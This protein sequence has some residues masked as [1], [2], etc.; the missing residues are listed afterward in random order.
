MT[1]HMTVITRFFLNVS[2]SIHH[3][4]SNLKAVLL[5]EWWW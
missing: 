2:P 4:Q 5:L 1:T 3:F